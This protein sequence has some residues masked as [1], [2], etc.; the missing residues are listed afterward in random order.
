MTR[1]WWPGLCAA[2]LVCMVGSVVVGADWP[3]WRGAERNGLSSETHLLQSWPAG[4]PKL[5][6]SADGLGRGFSSVAVAKGTIYTT[7]VLDVPTTTNDVKQEGFLFAFDLNG[8][9]KWKTDYG[10]EYT[11][12]YT[13]TRGTPSVDGKRVFVYS[14]P[15]TVVCCDARDGHILWSVDTVKAYGAQ[16]M[17]HGICESLL[18]VGKHVICCPGGKDASVVALEQKT[19][20]LAWRTP[21]ISETQGYNSAT[22]ITVHGQRTVVAMMGYSVFGLDPED[23]TVRW[24]YQYN[25]SKNGADWPCFTPLYLDDIL[26]LPSGTA[27]SSAEGFTIAPDNRGITR[28]WS[29]PKM[30]VHHGAVVIVGDYVYG[31][32]GCGP[33]D[34]KFLCLNVKTGQVMYESERVGY[35]NIIAADGLLFTYFQDG[36]LRLLAANPNAYQPISSFKIDKGNHQHWAHL[37]LS[38]GRLFVRHGD[39][40]MA[41]RVNE[42]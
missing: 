40:L 6:W 1:N 2:M 4:G 24:R 8:A 26:Y 35:A 17:L 14:G 13:G 11:R 3:Q 15:G 37:A 12:T 23:G 25:D 41:Y 32:P 16:V 9:L 20:K 29:Q 10:P 22:L 7:G 34:G 28:A 21:G 39:T 18:V 27:N 42:E 31:T 33:G 36:T 30:G 38:D 5:L 19:G